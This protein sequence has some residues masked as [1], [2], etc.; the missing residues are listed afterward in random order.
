MK[1]CGLVAYLQRRAL[2]RHGREAH[3]VAE[4]NG[5]AVERLGLH[6]LASLQLLGHRAAGVGGDSRDHH[7]CWG[8]GV[9]ERPLQSGECMACFSLFL[10]RVFSCKWQ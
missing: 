4:V 6:R 8:S 1:R 2:G 9:G 7:C 5:D 3:D 10:L